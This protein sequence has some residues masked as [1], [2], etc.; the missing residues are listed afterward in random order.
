[1]GDVV[2]LN[3]FRKQAARQQDKAR[4]EANRIQHGRSKAEKQTT[5]K[6]QDRIMRDLDGHK[7]TSED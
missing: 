4:A 5:T 6:A 3:R 1:M 7:L 2:N